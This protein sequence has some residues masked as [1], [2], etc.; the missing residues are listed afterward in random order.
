MKTKI[1]LGIS[2]FIILGLI[3]G[4]SVYFTLPSNN[5]GPSNSRI[6]IGDEPCYGSV[7]NVN[8]YLAESDSNGNKPDITSNTV[9]VDTTKL[10]NF[11]QNYGCYIGIITNT[12]NY[13]YIYYVTKIDAKNN[14]I[15][16]N[17]PLDFHLSSAE[18]WP[19]HIVSCKSLLPPPEIIR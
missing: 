15:T 9:N 10:I 17:A 13:T 6:Y 19:L 2:I 18:A 1:I 12:I 11:I 7:G 4:L 14:T 5:G 16:F 3:I 8:Y